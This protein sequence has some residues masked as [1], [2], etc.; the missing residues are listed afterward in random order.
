VGVTGND[1]RDFIIGALLFVA[2]GWAVDRMARWVRKQA[3][4][5]WSAWAAYRASFPFREVLGNWPKVRHVAPGVLV[6]KAPCIGPRRVQSFSGWK[7]PVLT[8]VALGVLNCL[9][10]GVSAKRED[11]AWVFA[12]AAIYGGL[13]SIPF[14]KMA[15]KTRLVI[16]FDQGEISWRGPD[17]KKQLVPPE[18]PRSLQVLL[19]HRW[20]NEERNKHENWMRSHPGQPGPKPLFQISSELVMHTGPGGMIWRTVAEFC[21]DGSGEQAHRLQMAID[22]VTDRAAEELRAR[23]KQAA[24]TGPL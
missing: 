12:G 8:G 22:F 9:R 20:A 11:L 7:P 19:P 3:R 13:I 21:N 23:A 24:E 18:E 16:R 2:A 15:Q 4:A 17:R 6:M 5:A 1:I 14:W 10:F